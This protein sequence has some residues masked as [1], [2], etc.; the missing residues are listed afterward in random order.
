[1]NKLVTYSQT[2][3]ANTTLKSSN[4]QANHTFNKIQPQNNKTITNQKNQPNTQTLKA[5]S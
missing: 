2:K 1:M 5:T 4:Q 3:R